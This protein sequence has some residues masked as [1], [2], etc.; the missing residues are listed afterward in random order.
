[1]KKKKDGKKFVVDKNVGH[2]TNNI[3]D[4]WILA[5]TQDLIKFVRQE[6]TAYRLYTVVPRLVTFIVDL[7]NWYVRLNRTRLKGKDGEVEERISL[8]TLFYVLYTLSRVMAPFTPYF[9][10]NLYQNLK[11]ILEKDERE[12]SV[13]FLSFPEYDDSL[14][15]EDIVRSVGRMQKVI[16]SGRTAR[17][18]K[19]K[20]CK[21]PVEDYDFI[22][23]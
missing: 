8:S 20:T 3:M 5:S 13:H 2:V 6:M 7:A 1:L 17:D 15:N 11:F 23:E 21:I 16:E 10:D 4:K 9:T 18:R 14:L 22:F 12:D 19:K